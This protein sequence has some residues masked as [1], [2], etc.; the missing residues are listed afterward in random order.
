MS[1]RREMQPSKLTARTVLASIAAFIL[2]LG[3]VALGIADIYF[4]REVLV[5]IY[6]RFSEN[7]E[8]GAVISTFSVLVLGIG[9]LVFI[10]VSGEYHVKHAG[11]LPSWKLFATSYIV[12]IFFAL[13]SNIMG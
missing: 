8:V 10:I 12:L 4:I 7:A 11:T 5:T 2:W 13:L 6:L 1:E 3:T 9:W